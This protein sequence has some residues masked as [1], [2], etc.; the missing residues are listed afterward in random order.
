MVSKILYITYD[1]LTDPLGR[2]QILPYLVGCA[3]RA[4][5]ISVLS[6]EKNDRFRTTG[7]TV[8]VL[9][10]KAG[11]D[12]RPL[13]YHNR[14]PIASSIYDSARL[15][16]TAASLMRNREF[17][18]VHCRSYL[19]AIA[20]LRLKRK[21]GVPLL[22]DMRGFWPEEK[23]ERGSW[24]LTNPVF[25]R[26][27]RYF[28]RL[29]S[30]LLCES[31]HIVSLTESGKRQLLSRVGYTRGPDPISVIPCSVDFNHFPL[32]EVLRADARAYLTIPESSQ[33][34]VYV[35]SLGGN[36]MLAEM[37]DFFLTFSRKHMNSVFLFLTVENPAPIF[38]AAA[39][40][41]V[42]TNKLKIQPATR[43]E[44]PRLLAAADVGIAF[45]RSTFSSLACSPTKLGEMLA[46]GI[47]VIA[48]SGVGDVDRVLTQTGTGVI[49]ESFDQDAYCAA[50]CDLRK[51]T[52][53]AKEIR[54]KAQDL[55]DLSN[56]V[57]RYSS[58][59]ETLGARS[60]R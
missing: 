41:G 29:E 17:D 20:G 27:Y 46:M 26:I 5:R 15:A 53:S 22:F 32:A 16:S 8:R 28:K 55:F 18:L 21:F 4:H 43:D 37:L 47:P 54:T 25:Q 44:M 3:A 48:N 6:C 52:V 36:Y 60:N 19:P 13:R 10:E 42:D 58:I 31:D 24:N 40:R 57:T 33:V 45:K 35:G 50:L 51:L 30:D 11:I 49:V 9:C 34:L 1:G 2:S 23:T 59:Y 12:W 56:A 7:S 14:P 39:R 38:A